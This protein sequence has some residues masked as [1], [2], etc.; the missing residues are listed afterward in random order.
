MK[1]YLEEIAKS[2]HLEIDEIDSFAEHFHN[3]S[4]ADLILGAIES[5]MWIYELPR[6]P[7]KFKKNP[8]CNSRSDYPDSQ[9]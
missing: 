4:E 3:I 6:R 1:Y 8:K 7:K 5:S 2:L 9:S